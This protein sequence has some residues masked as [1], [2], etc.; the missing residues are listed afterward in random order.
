MANVSQTLYYDYALLLKYLPKLT[1]LKIVIIDVSY[2]SF[3]RF[4]ADF[5]EYWRC[6]F[7]EKVYGIAPK[8][9]VLEPNMIFAP[10]RYSYIALYGVEQSRKQLFNNFKINF[11]DNIKP[12]GWCPSENDEKKRISPQKGKSRVEFHHSIMK[13]EHF[14]VNVKY[15]EDMIVMLKQKQI[16]PVL[17]TTPVYYT[18]SDYMDKEKYSRYQNKMNLLTI[19]YNIKYLNYLHD[20][21]FDINDY[22]NNDHLNTSGA[23]KFS[24]ILKED[25]L[26]V[27]TISSIIH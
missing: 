27:L 13:S 25:L 24:K 10:S 5:P 8:E 3:E 9:P 15:L 4:M 20:I 11:A 6:F 16:T 22:F 23:I 21:R 14:D 17:I 19:K 18:Y 7:Y 12:N 26:N 2:G 1:K